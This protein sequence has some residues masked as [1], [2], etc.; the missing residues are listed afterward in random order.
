MHD[1]LRQVPGPK[2]ITYTVNAGAIPTDHWTQDEAIGGGRIAGEACHFID[3]LRFLVGSTITSVQAT[4][5]PSGR[6]VIDTAV[7]TLRFTDGSIGTIQYFSAGGRAFP[8]ERLEAFAGGRTL[9]LDNFRRLRSFNWPAFSGRSLWRQ[10][11]GQDALAQR[12]LAAV[13]GEAALP[14]PIEELEESSRVT[15]ECAEA[16]RTRT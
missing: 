8:K 15:I 4:G 3:L 16:L 2:A 12:F 13:R 10:D 6:G 14:I 9:Q 11:K 1:L 5:Q 7:I